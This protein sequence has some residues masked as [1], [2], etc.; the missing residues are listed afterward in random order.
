MAWIEPE[1]SK[2]AVSRAGDHLL[3]NSLSE[4]QHSE[5]MLILNN[6]RSSHAFPLTIVQ[7]FLRAKANKIDRH[8]LIAQRL[9]RVPSI[10]GKLK[11]FPTMRLHRMQDI[12]GCRAVVADVK[13]VYKLRDDL[14]N[15]R[16]RHEFI[17]ENDYINHPKES[18]Y[19][20]IHL[21]YK[22]R[23]S[24]TIIYNDHMIEIQ[25]RTQLQHAW[26]TTVEIVGTFLK[27]SL[28]SSQ[29]PEEWLHFFKL[30][31]VL[32]SDLEECS[33]K[34]IVVEEIENIRAEARKLADKLYV[35]EKLQAFSV[36]THHIGEQNKS[37]G[38]FLLSLRTDK[39]TIQV[40]HYNKRDLVVATE[41][42]LELEKEY[43]NNVNANVVLVA[44]ASIKSLR[45]A[46]PNY[47]ADSRVFLE[48]L[49][50]VLRLTDDAKSAYI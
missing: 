40:N 6:W 23:S 27:E 46:Y 26:A 43:E 39:R 31:S 22:Y 17:K 35:I 4:E 5:A 7:T 33:P 42:Y 30:I 1:F 14:V 25:I 20:G 8:A 21:I 50:D 2:K 29:G 11:R 36:S 16:T 32:F 48:R 13:K 3:D 28:K 45:V 41:L 37:S 47:F 15:S 12:G 9:K 24:K 19:R 18:G 34:E 10:L 44:A 49:K 38:Y